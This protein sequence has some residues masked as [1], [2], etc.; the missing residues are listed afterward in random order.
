MWPEKQKYPTAEEIREVLDRNPEGAAPRGLWGDL[1]FL[2]NVSRP[3]PEAQG[4]PVRRLPR[5]RLE[6]PRD[7]Q[8]RPQ[9]QPAGRRRQDH[10]RRRS[11]EVRRKDAPKFAPVGQNAPGKAVHMMDIHAEKG[12]QCVDCHFAQDSHGNGQIYGEVAAPS[13]STARTATARRRPIRPCA[14]PGRRADPRASTCSLLRKPDGRR[15]FEWGAGRPPGADPALDAGSRSWSGRSSWSR[16]RS[17]AASPDFNAKAARAKLMSQDQPGRQ[18]VHLGPGRPAELTGAQ[19][20]GDGLLHLPPVVDHGCAGCHLPIEAN[21]KTERPLR[22]RR[23]A[24]LRHLQPAGRARRHVPA[25]QAPDGQGRRRS[26]RCARPRRWCCR[27]PT[28][29]ASGSTSS[30]RRS[31]PAASRRQAF[32]PHYP[33]TERKTETKT[34]S[35]CHVSEANDNNAIMAQLLLLGTNFVNF[36]GFNAWVGAARAASRRCR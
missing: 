6:L 19:R 10:R 30:S 18:A 25:G 16:T 36:V 2:R 28:S 11:G 21:W 33:H 3:Q 20:R 14:P 7:L 31:R 13:R 8:A 35:D 34:C 1:D 32:A 15:R 12:M 26:R 29:T 27:R 5:P 23:D 17:T 9:G 4:H 24:Q 22:G